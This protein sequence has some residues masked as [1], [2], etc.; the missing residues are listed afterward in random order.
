[1]LPARPRRLPYSHASSHDVPYHR[2][3]RGSSLAGA[4]LVTANT[5]AHLQRQ[6]PSPPPHTDTDRHESRSL[7]CPLKHPSPPSPSS[8]NSSHDAGW[9]KIEDLLS[10]EHMRLNANRGRGSP[11]SSIAALR[12]LLRAHV[13]D[14]IWWF[15]GAGPCSA[16]HMGSSQY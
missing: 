9:T 2:E 1:M 12:P 15:R 14:R 6:A 16:K 7:A 4:V 13:A 5:P 3:T 10:V 11:G 8:L